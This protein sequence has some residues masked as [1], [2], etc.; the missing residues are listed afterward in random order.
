VTELANEAANCESVPNPGQTDT[1]GD[2]W[3]LNINVDTYVTVGGDI[4]PYRGRAG[5]WCRLTSTGCS[6]LTSTAPTQ[7]PPA[8]LGGEECTEANP[9]GKL[10]RA[11]TQCCRL[12]RM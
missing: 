1:D 6:A 4:L 3:P 9:P 2:T 10:R 7:I 8:L 11:R 5:A 12:T